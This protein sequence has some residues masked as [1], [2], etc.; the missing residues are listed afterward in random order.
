MDSGTAPGH[1]RPA[2]TS[3]SVRYGRDVLSALR[4]ALDRYDRPRD[5]RGAEIRIG[6][7]YPIVLVMW[8]F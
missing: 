5:E 6:R 3:S 7:D 4:A 2:A 8:S 1:R